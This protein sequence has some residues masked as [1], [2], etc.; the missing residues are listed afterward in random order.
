MEHRNDGQ[1]SFAIKLL[2]QRQEFG[3]MTNVQKVCW[4]IQKENRRI[5]RERESDPGPLPFPT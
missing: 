1:L 2:Q 4:F 3:L 5:L